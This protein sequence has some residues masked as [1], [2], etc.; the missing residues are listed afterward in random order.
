VDAV[1]TSLSADINYGIPDAAGL[2]VEDTVGAGDADAHGVDEDVA[3]VGAV[4]GALAAD[5]RHADAI[6]I[7]AD[8][9]N[10]AGQQ[11]PRLRVIGSP[12]RSASVP[13]AGTW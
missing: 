13:P 7:A 1:A 9:G 6:A 5:C 8:A 2:G 3:V 11:M 10:D 4:E 12:K